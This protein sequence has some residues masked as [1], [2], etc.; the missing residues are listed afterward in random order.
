MLN[1]QFLILKTKNF[2]LN[3]IFK[4]LA[5]LLKQRVIGFT[6]KF[7]SVTNFFDD[8]LNLKVTFIPLIYYW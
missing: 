6:P 7:F 1:F 5:E 3:L 4:I 8:K 2:Q